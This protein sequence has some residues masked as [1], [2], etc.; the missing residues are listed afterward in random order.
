MC[1]LKSLY[2]ESLRYSLYTCFPLLATFIIRFGHSGLNFWKDVEES[3]PV[4]FAFCISL[5]LLLAQMI[6][7]IPFMAKY[8]E[9]RNDLKQ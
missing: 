6:Y 2:K 3:E 5:G 1:I 7:F 4:L 8:C 9:N